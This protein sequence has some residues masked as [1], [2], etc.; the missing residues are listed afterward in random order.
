MHEDILVPLKKRKD[1]ALLL[2]TKF[3]DLQVEYEEKKRE[4]EEGPQTK[5]DWA[6]AL[7]SFQT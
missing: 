3:K 1:E 6:V 4:L 5:R 2:V 7:V